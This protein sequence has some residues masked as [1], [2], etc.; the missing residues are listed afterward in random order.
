M[1]TPPARHSNQFQQQTPFC[2]CRQSVNRN[3]IPR[4]FLFA[5]SFAIVLYQESDAVVLSVVVDRFAHQKPKQRKKGSFYLLVICDC[6]HTFLVIHFILETTV[7]V[8]IDDTHIHLFLPRFHFVCIFNRI[9]QRYISYIF[10][11]I[12]VL[13]FFGVFAEVLFVLSQILLILL[14]YLYQHIVWPF[15]SSPA[16]VCVCVYVS[17]SFRI[18]NHFWSLY[19]YVYNN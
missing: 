2:L 4:F 7:S 6:E 5:H 16:C 10:S 14:H 19:E 12:E 9:T 17:G 3:T 11:S 18:V 13:F 8:H 1:L 15:D